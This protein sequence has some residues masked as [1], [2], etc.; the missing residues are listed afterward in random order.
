MER[1]SILSA[2]THTALEKRSRERERMR[3]QREMEREGLSTLVQALG[4]SRRERVL[5]VLRT[6]FFF[7][8]EI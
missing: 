4:E 1:E 6:F 7:G 2:L 3:K 5:I 8:S